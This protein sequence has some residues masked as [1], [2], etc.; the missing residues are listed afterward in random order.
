M[1]EIT[2]LL[3]TTNLNKNMLCT[4]NHNPERFA[5]CCVL[6]CPH[7]PYNVMHGSLESNDVCYLFIVDPSECEVIQCVAYY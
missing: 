6:V 2:E 7:V 4:I 5:L 1:K 3:W